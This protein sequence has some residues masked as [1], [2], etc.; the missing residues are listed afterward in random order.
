M[1]SAD[2]GATP[3]N[4]SAQPLA[5]SSPTSE[6]LSALLKTNPMIKYVLV[7][8]D[9][10]AW[11]FN[12]VKTT[13]DKLQGTATWWLERVPVEA[14][15][16]LSVAMTEIQTILKQTPVIELLDSHSSANA[17]IE[18]LVN[19]YASE[20]K[21]RTLVQ[22]FFNSEA[23]FVKSNRE[24]VE[25]VN[26]LPRQENLRVFMEPYQALAQQDF[27]TDAAAATPVATSVDE[28]TL[29]KAQALIDS[30]I[31]KKDDGTMA[32]TPQFEERL[33]VLTDS[34]IMYGN[35]AKIFGEGSGN[36]VDENEQKTLQAYAIMTTQRVT[37]YDLLSSEIIRELTKIEPGTP[38]LQ[39]IKEETLA[40]FKSVAQFTLKANE[41]KRQ[42]EALQ[43]LL[44]TQAV[45]G[46]I[47]HDARVL[48]PQMTQLDATQLQ[49][50]D[51]F[52]ARMTTIASDIVKDN[53]YF[54]LNR[55]GKTIQASDK[56]YEVF[57]DTLVAAALSQKGSANT[58][59]LP[60]M[61]QYIK[62]VDKKLQTESMP[63]IFLNK[64]SFA[65]SPTS[66]KIYSTMEKA[67]EATANRIV[68][69]LAKAVAAAEAAYSDK[70][71]RNNALAIVK[72]MGPRAVAVWHQQ[73]PGQAQFISIY[74]D[75]ES[76]RRSISAPVDEAQANPVIITSM[77][78]PENEINQGELFE[79]L[80]QDILGK[81]AEE[82]K[83]KRMI[84]AQYGFTQLQ[85][86]DNFSKK[87][88]E[89]SKRIVESA[90]IIKPEEF[91]ETF[92]QTFI[93]GYITHEKAQN[94]VFSECIRG[95]ITTVD[96]YFHQ[97]N[98]SGVVYAKLADIPGTSNKDAPA[99]LS[100]SD[101]GR[102]DLQQNM[103]AEL[104]QNLKT[105]VE[106]PQ[107]GDYEARVYNRT[108]DMIN[109]MGSKAVMLWN[110]HADKEFF[111]LSLPGTK[112]YSDLF[113]LGRTETDRRKNMVNM[114][115]TELTAM[116]QA[117]D[118]LLASE[119]IPE[120]L[121]KQVSH[122]L[123]QAL[124]TSQSRSEMNEKIKSA[125][126][127]LFSEGYLLGRIEGIV[128]SQS[129][130]LQLIDQ[131]IIRLES[132]LANNKQQGIF[133]SNP[134]ELTPFTLLGNYTLADTV[135]AGTKKL[136]LPAF[137]NYMET[138]FNDVRSK[139]DRHDAQKIFVN[140]VK[141]LE[142]TGMGAKEK[143]NELVKKAND[144]LARRISL[145]DV[146]IE[147]TEKKAAILAA[148]QLDGSGIIGA[149][150]LKKLLEDENRNLGIVTTGP[151]FFHSAPVAPA[152]PGP[153][154]EKPERVVTPP[155]LPAK[156]PA[157]TDIKEKPD[158]A[159]NQ[160][161]PRPATPP[162]LPPRK[163]AKAIIE[164]PTPTPPP[165][166]ERPL[167]PPPVPPRK[168]S[169]S[170]EAPSLPTESPKTVRTPPPLP[171]PLPATQP[172]INKAADAKANPPSLPRVP[173]SQSFL[174]PKKPKAPPLPSAPPPK[175]G[176]KPSS[177]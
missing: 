12:R 104:F 25:R 67:D 118:K 153:I 160:E 52:L 163:S 109:A 60:I 41:I 23:S 45:L 47:A 24:F 132:S 164:E 93:D 151:S 33:K 79:L 80:N 155:P 19:V 92:M 111:E 139:M 95:F 15:V 81:I 166:P 125:I 9:Q 144:P 78:L 149:R 168:P 121:L 68:T 87:V 31:T 61:L 161:P 158:V 117:N 71:I 122:Q 29:L 100:L 142:K 120:D 110:L 75:L 77:A 27:L 56:F 53:I 59:L 49:I 133:V 51:D 130:A 143:W 129:N 114:V 39:K 76:K 94:D 108:L 6:E 165:V 123:Q 175:G 105:L 21:R 103:V 167:T 176:R 171:P 5:S 106:S 73:E 11:G 4:L 44:S 16:G 148:G 173:P 102:N 46:K 97:H 1:Q 36:N 17:R 98:L 131:F 112:A 22:E 128:T 69:K 156:Q 124:S 70:D 55:D 35:F 162:P 99:L 2:A 28:A 74:S 119:R 140:A 34:V 141:L 127:K 82:L 113:Q 89:V 126:L 42:T 58:G 174:S 85:I 38:E 13:V 136:S 154:A 159:I 40:K 172:R 88:Q 32:M 14:D 63:V 101:R 26:Q 137:N 116:Q 157:K 169:K 20:N 64:I 66:K 96:K 152:S 147:W 145:P 7:Q 8:D 18:T 50:W 83:A 138:L 48:T 54:S 84:A 90:D 146:R 115:T 37:R 3:V 72:A 30:L 62:A 86:W 107:H 91:Y 135:F 43:K 134:Q 177:G 57:M 65:F 10:G 150:K 170:K